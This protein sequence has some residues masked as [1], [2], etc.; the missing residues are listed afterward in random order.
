MFVVF[1]VWATIR[2]DHAWRQLACFAWVKQLAWLHEEPHLISF[3]CQD[4]AL[5]PTAASP[6]RTSTPALLS[7]WYGFITCYCLYACT[8]VI[9][10]VLVWKCSKT[11]DIFTSKGSGWWWKMFCFFLNLDLPEL[12]DD[13][14]ESNHSSEMLPDVEHIRSNINPYFF[15]YWAAFEAE[16]TWLI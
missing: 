1:R 7:E 6:F 4:F 5:E 8:Q 12:P 14:L 11:D 10:C 16:D 2:W 15:N 9:V 3:E 13:E